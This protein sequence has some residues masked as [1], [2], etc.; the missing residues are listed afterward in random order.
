MSALPQA[1]TPVGS[2]QLLASVWKRSLPLVRQRLALLSRTAQQAE[3]GELTQS[4]RR[5]AAETAHKLAGSLG[6]FGY[7]DGTEIA[8]QLEILLEAEGP[9]P[10]AVQELTHQLEAA[11]PV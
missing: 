5:E 7:L 9:V 10:S 3:A 1:L 2:Q 4:A 11:V 6:M 8:R